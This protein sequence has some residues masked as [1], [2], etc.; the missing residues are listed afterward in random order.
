MLA[1]FSITPVGTGESVGELVAE[2]VRAVRQLA[3]DMESLQ[4]RLRSAS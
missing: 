4:R 3:R 1:A 2:A